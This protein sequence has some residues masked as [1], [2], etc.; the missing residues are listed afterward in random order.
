M[1]TSTATGRE[2]ALA[3]RLLFHRAHL[4]PDRHGAE[5]RRRAPV[6]DARRRAHR[7]RAR[8]RL[9]HRAPRAGDPRAH[10]RPRRRHRPLA[11]DD[12]ARARGGAGGHR[13]RHRRRRGPRHARR[14]STP[15]SATRRSSGSRT[16]RARWPTASRR[17]VPGGRMAMQ[18]PAR[19]DYCPQ[20]VH[21]VGTLAATRGPARPGRRFRTPWTFYETARGVRAAVHRRRVRRSSPP[22]SRSCGSTRPR[23]A[24]STCSSRGRPRAT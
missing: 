2:G 4:P 21:A 13:V 19:H 7:R 5:V 10:R 23:S 18:A 24:P 8:S 17:C 22:R 3:E 11:R 15:S 1:M 20:F 9:R 6:L 12:R 16:S 14:S